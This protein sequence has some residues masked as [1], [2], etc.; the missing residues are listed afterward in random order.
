[1]LQ[2]QLDRTYLRLQLLKSISAKQMG[3]QA[4]NASCCPL[5]LEARGE[6]SLHNQGQC[7]TQSKDA[8]YNA[9]DHK[10]QALVLGCAQKQQ[11]SSLPATKLIM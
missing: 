1:V 4:Q 3:F 11:N 7:P 8:R 5:I 2:V 9:Q 10:V 6:I